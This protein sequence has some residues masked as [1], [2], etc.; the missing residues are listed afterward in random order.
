MWCAAGV[1]AIVSI[2]LDKLRAPVAGCVVLMIWIT[3]SGF[4]PKLEQWQ[5]WGAAAV[6]PSLSPDRWYAELMYTSTITQYKAS[7]DIREPFQDWPSWSVARFWH[8]AASLLLLGCGMH[9]VAGVLLVLRIDPAAAGG[10]GATGVAA[11]CRQRL[12]ES[13]CCGLGARARRRQHSGAVS[14]SRVT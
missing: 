3:T 4:D 11:G 13:F 6:V 2:V 9:A 7:W 5:Q 8:C 14:S 1:G 10:G 12:F